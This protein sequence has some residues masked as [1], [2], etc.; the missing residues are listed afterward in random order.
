MQDFG[1]NP[2]VLEQDGFP[3]KSNENTGMGDIRSYVQFS[4]RFISKYILTKIIIQNIHKIKETPLHKK[5]IIIGLGIPLGTILLFWL[6][7][8][9]LFPVAIIDGVTYD[10]HKLN[11]LNNQRNLSHEALLITINDEIND[12]FRKQLNYLFLDIINNSDSKEIHNP[13]HRILSV[14]SPEGLRIRNRPSINGERIFLLPDKT[15]VEEI[16]KDQQIVKIDGINGKWAYI[17]FGNIY[18]WVFDGYLLEMNELVK[19]IITDYYD[20]VKENDTLY[21]SA[22]GNYKINNTFPLQYKKHYDIT[23][24][25]HPNISVIEY[26]DTFYD[27]N[28]FDI[29]KN[30]INTLNQDFA[31]ITNSQINII[32]GDIYRS[33][34]E[35][36]RDAR[37][38]ANDMFYSKDLSEYLFRIGNVADFSIDYFSQRPPA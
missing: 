38:V 31:S 33:Y 2:L 10:K 11:E 14:N 22:L 20:K 3:N 12:L 35:I 13:M 21:F 36:K 4:S 30:N 24:I 28:A 34:E 1:G 6:I 32:F 37:N 29:L 27:K 18:G 19:N 26:G 5:K 25:F 15:L 17:R 8:I 9:L 23:D 16:R 7:C